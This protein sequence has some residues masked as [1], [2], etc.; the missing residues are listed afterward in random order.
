MRGLDCEG[1]PFP[2]KIIKR[3]S[4]EERKKG[5]YKSLKLGRVAEFD[6][7]GTLGTDVILDVEAGRGGGF[8][9]TSEDLS[10]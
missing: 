10:A 6:R 1:T 9:A 7:D 2:L 5:T 3:G 4:I 8:R